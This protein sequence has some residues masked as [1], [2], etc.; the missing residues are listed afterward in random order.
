M[1]L[2]LDVSEDSIADLNVQLES[3][4]TDA[5]NELQVRQSLATLLSCS[6]S[7]QVECP[8]LMLPVV[9]LEQDKDLQIE[10]L[11]Q[12]LQLSE[13]NVSELHTQLQVAQ[14]DTNDE[15]DVRFAT[16]SLSSACCCKRRGMCQRCFGTTAGQASAA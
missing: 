11:Q 4:N 14:A 3:G 15:L 1:Q 12:R 13:D 6:S 7:V 2:Q 5:A 10:Q 9:I 16:C 8:I